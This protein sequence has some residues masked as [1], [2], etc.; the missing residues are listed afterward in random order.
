MLFFGRRVF[1]APLKSPEQVAVDA[2][3]LSDSRSPLSSLA[4]DEILRAGYKSIRCRHFITELSKRYEHAIQYT[5]KSALPSR[6]A[7]SLCS[8]LR[9][10]GLLL[11]EFH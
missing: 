4:S 1:P 6:D 11:S 5:K 3:P 2:V 8:P 9:T 7:V 10:C